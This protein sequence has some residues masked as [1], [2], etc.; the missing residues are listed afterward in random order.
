MMIDQGLRSVV[1]MRKALWADPQ[2]GDPIVV[3]TVASLSLLELSEDEFMSCTA[4]QLLQRAY[5]T[6]SAG[7]RIRDMQLGQARSRPFYSLHPDERLILVLLH[8]EHWSYTRIAELLE[9]SV[10]QLEEIAWR[11]RIQLSAKYPIASAVDTLSCPEYDIHRPWIQKFLDDQYT[12]ATEKTFLQNHLMA[13]NSC[14]RALNSCRDVYYAVDAMIPRCE[15]DHE[16]TQLLY[17]QL[18]KARKMSEKR[19]QSAH[20]RARGQVRTSFSHFFL[21]LLRPDILAVLLGLGFLVKWM[22]RS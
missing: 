12:N 6:A 14:R 18:E 10:L 3:D 13:C 20:R 1:Q 8:L 21:F 15:Q 17:R 2:Q 19:I 9:I 16:E 11:I 7:N 5:R 4:S 22:M